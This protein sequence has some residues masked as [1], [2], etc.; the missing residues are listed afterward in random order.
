MIA[1]VLT[2]RGILSPQINAFEQ[3][4]HR[5][6]DTSL[7]NVPIAHHKV[8]GEKKPQ[9]V[10]VSSGLCHYVIVTKNKTRGKENDTDILNSS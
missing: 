2:S 3:E 5:D 10:H 1:S 9:L 8:V 6:V 7:V 4:P